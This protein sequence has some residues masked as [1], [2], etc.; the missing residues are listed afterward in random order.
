MMDEQGVLVRD[1][2]V[3][4]IKSIKKTLKS[5]TK[6]FTQIMELQLQNSKQQNQNTILIQQILSYFSKPNKKPQ[7]MPISPIR[8]MVHK[9]EP[10]DFFL[11]KFEDTDIYNNENLQNELNNP[12]KISIVN[13]Q[14]TPF[15]SAYQSINREMQQYYEPENQVTEPS[16]EVFQNFKKMGQQ[17]VKASLNMEGFSLPQ[18]TKNNTERKQFIQPC[19]H[20]SKQLQ[21][22]ESK[23]NMKNSKQLENKK[24]KI[25]DQRLS[26]V[27]EEPLA[28]LN[29][30]QATKQVLLNIGG[31]QNI[32]Q[33]CQNKNSFAGFEFQI[34]LQQCISKTPNNNTKPQNYFADNTRSGSKSLYQN[35]IP[36]NIQYINNSNNKQNQIKYEYL[37]S[38]AK[39]FSDQ[40]SKRNQSKKYLDLELID[41]QY[42]NSQEILKKTNTMR[43]T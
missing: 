29:S 37:S 39:S 12:K 34:P 27:V 3:N 32:V 4:D 17:G 42:E 21:L 6:V 16:A 20:S 40:N 33:S 23:E 41:K 11:R 7:Q 26:T 36:Q 28:F 18:S 1:L 31:S 2:L 10:D 38:R 9:T 8:K 5:W 30:Q 25:K 43:K 22:Q 15:D 14:G 24:I 35:N 13:Y 19:T